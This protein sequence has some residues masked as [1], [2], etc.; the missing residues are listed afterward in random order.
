LL[1]LGA[2]IPRI[3]C[4][5]SEA[6]GSRDVG[7]PARHDGIVRGATDHLSA[8][9]HVLYCVRLSTNLRRR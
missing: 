9:P 4:G 5:F 2:G 6:V 8:F 1:K 3:G 7:C